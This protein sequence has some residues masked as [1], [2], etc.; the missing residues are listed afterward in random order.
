MTQNINSL[1]PKEAN[2]LSTFSSQGKKIFT[3]KEAR[4]FWGAASYTANVL[5]RLKTKGWL[6]RLEP[7]TY[8]I[9]PLEAGP[10]RAWSESSLVIAPHLIQPATIAYWSALHYWHMTEQIPQTVFVQS[11]RRKHHREKE[12][13]GIPFRF[14]TVVDSKFFN[15][16]KRTLHGKPI[17]VT[18]REKTIVDAAD[19][20]DLSGGIAQLAQALR[21]ARNELSW[22]KLDGVLG[23]WPTKTPYKRIGYLVESM[24]LPLPEK[25]Q[26]LSR[27]R[28]AISAGISALEPGRKQD[29]GHIITRWGIRINIEETWLSAGGEQ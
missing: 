10:E 18:D 5:D 12:I 11:T 2:F 4:S 29:E 17:Y 9:I 26:R 6:Q 22:E 20:P 24:Q 25:K 13:L 8:M 7:G 27:W 21:T 19:R 3:S 1:G 28:E 16:T 14:V 23:R 15:V